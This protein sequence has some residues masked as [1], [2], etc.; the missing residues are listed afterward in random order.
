MRGGLLTYII[1]QKILGMIEVAR[2]LAGHYEAI[3]SLSLSGW[4]VREVQAGGG[5]GLQAQVLPASPPIRMF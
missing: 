1:P 3:T 2:L 5:V 4:I